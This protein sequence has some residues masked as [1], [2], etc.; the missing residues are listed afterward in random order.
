MITIHFDFTDGS[1][2]S[3]IEGLEAEQG[4]TTNC[5]DFFCFDVLDDVKVIKKDGSYI[6]K[7]ELLGSSE[8]TDKEIREAHNIQKMLKAN[9]FSWKKVL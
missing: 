9:S 2:L 8:Y 5:L 7:S 4:F 1:E 3:Y 6:L